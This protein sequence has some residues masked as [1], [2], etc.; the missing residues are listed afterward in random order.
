MNC[1]GKERLATGN[2]EH[3]LFTA[4]VVNSVW[5][6]AREYLTC[7]HLCGAYSHEC[8]AGKASK[9]SSLSIDLAPRLSLMD[10]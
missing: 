2:A 5:G 7:Q 1:W 6:L 4:M 8:A 10:R 9:Y 3:E